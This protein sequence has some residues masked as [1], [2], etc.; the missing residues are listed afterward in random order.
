MLVDLLIVALILDTGVFFES[1]PLVLQLGHFLSKTVS[2]H[3]E[4]F[5]VF[6]SISQLSAII[7]QFITL[8]VHQ[9]LVFQTQR[10]NDALM[11]F[12]VILSLLVELLLKSSYSGQVLLLLEKDAVSLQIGILDSLFTL[13]CQLLDGFLLLFVESNPLLLIFE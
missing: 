6:V 4:P 1:S 7:S 11:A 2:V 10:L 5:R 12:L 13:I 8:L 9:C 3:A